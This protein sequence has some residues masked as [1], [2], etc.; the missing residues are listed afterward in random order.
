MLM[1]LREDDVAIATKTGE[2]TI[3]IG[4][5]TDADGKLESITLLQGSDM[6]CIPVEIAREVASFIRS[7]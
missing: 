1:D 6:I 7:K 4:A 5:I 2:W 3:F